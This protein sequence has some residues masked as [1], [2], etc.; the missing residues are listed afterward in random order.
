[1][2]RKPDLSGNWLL[3]IGGWIFFAGWLVVE[4]VRHLGTR[5]PD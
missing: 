1:M 3:T 4:Y 5:R 2:N